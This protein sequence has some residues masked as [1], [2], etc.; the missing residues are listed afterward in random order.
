[1]ATGGDNDK[2]VVLITG[3]GG[4]LGAELAVQVAAD[5]WEPVLLDRRL[6]VLEPVRQRILAAGRPEPILLPLDL[7]TLNP[8]RCAEIV[9]A[10]KTGPGRLD[11]LVHCAAAFDGLR[12]MEQIEPSTW[13]YDFQ[14]NV[15]AAWLLSVQ[16]LQL[17]RASAAATLV[18]VLDDLERMAG[19]HWGAY[20]V[21]KWALDAMAAQFA[22]ELRR[23]S[24]RVCAV[25]PGPL[26]SPLRAAAFHTEDPA[27]VQPASRPA[28]KIL[29]LLNTTG[30]LDQRRI[31]LD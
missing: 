6:A 11:A 27:A 19:A 12:P 20:G 16:A 3:A 8:D 1:M 31:R 25:D 2:G 18:F 30:K 22:A 14:V 7:A 15:H 10:L 9:T 13:L 26:R 5:G 23:S 24:V 28:G 21:S 29:Q 17:L 4:A